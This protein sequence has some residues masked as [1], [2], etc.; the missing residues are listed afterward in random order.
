MADR[1]EALRRAVDALIQEREPDM[2]RYYYA[3]LYGVSHFCALL[4][5]RRRLRADIAVA[6]GMLHDIHTLVTGDSAQHA[7]QGAPRAEALLRAVGGFA[8]EEI[9][10]IAQAVSRHSAKACV[11][12]PCDEVLKDADVLH[13]ALYNPTFAIKQD[14][15]V[16]FARVMAELGCPATL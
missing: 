4:A 12:A 7:A 9:A 16:R 1:I 10:C 8:E 2:Q 11:H 6:S 14:E 5:T 15:Q 13:H 3:H